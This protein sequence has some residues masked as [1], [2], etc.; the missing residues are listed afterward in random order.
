MS[1]ERAIARY[2]GMST[3][4]AIT[5]TLRLAFS[6][7]ARRLYWLS[8]LASLTSLLAATNTLFATAPENQ[9]V[10]A[11]YTPLSGVV[12]IHVRDDFSGTGSVIGKKQIGNDFWLCVL[13][14]NHVVANANRAWQTFAPQDVEVGIK[15]LG[16]PMFRT[17]FIFTALDSVNN[18][19]DPHRNFFG[20]DRP[21]IALIGVRVNQQVFN[22]VASYTMA[23]PGHYTDFTIVGY[24]YTGVTDRDT[25]GNFI[26]YTMVRVP[27]WHQAVCQQHGFYEI[28]R[29]Q[30]CWG[31]SSGCV[32]QVG[33]HDRRGG[34]CR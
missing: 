11:N 20:Q 8:R 23:Q 25:D 33:S 16:G 7:Y 10:P 15:N 34:S 13:T 3:V 21:D 9:G 1:S 5:C 22:Q 29:Q 27:E 18:P 26:G 6:D 28:R 14:A 30:P 17:S 32:C 19:N 24:G 4:K 12:R 2:S 31:S